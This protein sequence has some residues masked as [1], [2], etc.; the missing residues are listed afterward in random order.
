[1]FRTTLAGFALVATLAPLVPAAAQERGGLPVRDSS[2][3]LNQIEADK[4]CRLSS[5]SVNVGVN[6]ATGNG[7]S[8][9]QRQAT[10]AGNQPA[11]CKPLVR[12]QVVTGVNLGL[13][14][15]STAGQSIDATGS[16][17]GLATT[18]FTRGVNAGVGAGSTANQ[19]LSNTTT[20]R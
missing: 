2:V 4:G 6:K 15:G 14:R 9:Q 16:Q 5:T 12:T 10:A 17:G 13:G 11:G 8:A 7:S 20:G 18:T 19:R 1:M 3:T